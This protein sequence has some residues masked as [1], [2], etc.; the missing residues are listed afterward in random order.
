MVDPL[1]ARIVLALVALVALVLFYL[2]TYRPTR[3]RYA[4][5]WCLGLVGTGASTAAY[6]FNGTDLQGILNPVGNVFAVGGTGFVWF[7]TRA[8]RGQR[9]AWHVLGGLMAAVAIAT[10]LGDPAE[11][12]WAG[13]G[14]LIAAMLACLVLAAREVW[15]LLKERPH[16]GV[17]D[18]QDGSRVALLSLYAA[19][20]VFGAWYAARL[21]GY[22]VLGPDDA[23]LEE[24]F[25]TFTTSVILAIILL[26]ATFGMSE[27]ATYELTRELRFKASYDYLTGLLTRSEFLAR[28]EQRRVRRSG[29]RILIVAD[30]DHFKE[31]N[32]ALG[33]AAGDRALLAFGAVCRQAVEGIGIAGRIGGEEFAILVDTA[34]MDSARKVAARI[35]ESYGDGAPVRLGRATVSYGATSVAAGE[36][37]ETAMLRADDALYEAKRAGRDR[38]EILEAAVE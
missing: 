22:F 13:A 32:D 9:P 36:D 30:L 15:L 7:A 18:S 20:V 37:L 3:A 16:T 2:G 38:F 19:S 21:I 11:D 8:I 23:R 34:Q 14:V 5:W 4:L 28:A 26:I 6:S 33:H 24:W 17:P 27:L 12:E 29:S 35:S 10:I 25:G 1:T 31:L